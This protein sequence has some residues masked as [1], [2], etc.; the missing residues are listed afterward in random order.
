MG[1]APFPF[2]G[3]HSGERILVGRRSVRAGMARSAWLGRSLALPGIQ[4][5]VLDFRI[6][7]SLAY[8]ATP[9][10]PDS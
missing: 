10:T 5:L 1:R 7:T 6:N 9:A 8:S 4:E 3:D 2:Y